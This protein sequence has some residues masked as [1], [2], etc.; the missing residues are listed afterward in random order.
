MALKFSAFCNLLHELERTVT[1][2]P[3][4]LPAR[5]DEILHERTSMWFRQNRQ[6]IDLTDGVAILSTFLPEQRT[7]RVYQLQARSLSKIIGRCYQMPSA[8]FDKLRKYEIPGHGDLAECLERDQRLYDAEPRVQLNGNAGDVTVEEVDRCMQ[9]LAGRSRFSNPDVR[10]SARQDLGGV[11]IVELL[12]PL[13]WR[14]RSREAKWLTRLILKN[15]SPVVFN[16]PLVLSCYHFLLPSLLKFQNDFA[17]AVKLLKGQ[18]SPLPS[19]TDVDSAA[20]FRYMASENL[21]PQINVKV[22]RP[23]HHKAWSLN[24]CLKL[25]GRRKWIVERKYDGEFAEIH[26]DLTANPDPVGTDCIRIFSKS[27]KDSTRDRANVHDT[28]KRSLKLGTPQCLIKRK[29]ILLAEMVVWSDRDNKVLPFDHIRR[30]VSRSGSYYGKSLDGFSSDY[31]SENLALVYFDMLLLD[32]DV[33][34]RKHHGER[35]EVLGRVVKKIRGRSMTAL[36]RQIDFGSPD[37]STK[38]AKQ[39]GAALGCA[40]EGLL[41]KPADQP[42]FTFKHPSKMNELSCH[43]YIKLKKDYLVSLGGERDVCDLAVVGGLYDA[44]GEKQMA[45]GTKGVK[46]TKFFLGCLTNPDE[47]RFNGI[48]VFQVVAGLGDAEII[49]KAI[50]KALNDD[51]RFKASVAGSGSSD[52]RVIGY[53]GIEK[54]ELEE[55]SLFW[56]PPV[57]EILGSGF[58]RPPSCD[59]MMLRHPRMLK[60]HADRTWVDALTFSGLQKDATESNKTSGLVTGISVALV[61]RSMGV[62]QYDGDELSNKEWEAELVQVVH[63]VSR[64][65]RANIEAGTSDLDGIPLRHRYGASVSMSMLRSSLSSTLQTSSAGSTELETMTNTGFTAA[66]SSSVPTRPPRLNRELTRT[67]SIRPSGSATVTESNTTILPT[68]VAAD[69][70]L[71]STDSRNT[72]EN[73]PESRSQEFSRSL[74]RPRREIQSRIQKVSPPRIL[75]D[76]TNEAER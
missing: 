39:L 4:L 35:R 24:N 66:I 12:R 51:V 5:R 34:M 17:A 22:G 8:R 14:L 33:V 69:G 3:P 13:Y 27:G 10:R 46:Y 18:F 67:P 65:V 41:L 36:Y 60:F 16:P 42:Y 57:V 72:C 31:S 32:D 55:M 11:P 30:H 75:E 74:K 49:P 9:Q 47:V 59:F 50:F 48:P 62:D 38:L 28:I 15:F 63:E 19:S 68:P 61:S 20:G 37:A 71:P 73:V 52:M 26:I 45:R 1:K 29:A 7:D 64:R 53:S 6:A 2:D 70:G 76:V 44:L 25:C 43:G 58:V 40:A 54:K 56:P 23:T 21:Q